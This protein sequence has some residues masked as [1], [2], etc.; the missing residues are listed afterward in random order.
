MLRRVAKLYS[1]GV[2]TDLLAASEEDILILQSLFLSK[3]GE[4]SKGP[5]SSQV[6]DRWA[7]TNTTAQTTRQLAT[8]AAEVSKDADGQRH[9]SFILATGQT[10]N[11]RD[12]G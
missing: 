1:S 10:N 11:R 9:D 3:G 6:P 12:D 5:K 2:R 8:T 7:D 4:K